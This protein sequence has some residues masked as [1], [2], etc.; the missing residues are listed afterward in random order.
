MLTGVKFSRKNSWKKFVRARVCDI[1]L[2]YIIFSIYSLCAENFI[3]NRD[4][5]HIY[6]NNPSFFS[7]IHWDIQYIKPWRGLSVVSRKRITKSPHYTSQIKTSCAL[8][9]NKRLYIGRIKRGIRRPY[10]ALTCGKNTGG[11]LFLVALFVFCFFSSL[12]LFAPPSLSPS[13]ST[14]LAL[15]ESRIYTCLILNAESARKCG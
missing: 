13:P 7:Y 4:Y 5:S 12:S 14:S 3:Y 8:Y 1:Y 11:L 9:Q 10:L 15:C 6:W 2:F